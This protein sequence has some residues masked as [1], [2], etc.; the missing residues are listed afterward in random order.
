LTVGLG[1][2]CE[3]RQSLVSDNLSPQATAVTL[4]I[5]NSHKKV[6]KTLTLGTKTVSVWYAVKW[7]PKAKGSYTYTVTASDLAGNTQTKA[8]SAKIT[9]KQ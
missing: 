7:T 4:T 8:G 5:R 3:G 9:V 2:A 6:V 1:R